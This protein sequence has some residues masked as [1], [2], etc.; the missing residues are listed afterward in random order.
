MKKLGVFWWNALAQI[1]QG[2]DVVGGSMTAKSVG[3]RALNI[4]IDV[5]QPAHSDF[6]LLGIPER[7]FRKHAQRMEPD[8]AVFIVGGGREGF[9]V[10]GL[11]AVE[12]P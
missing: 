9:F 8:L 11:E 10:Q 4:G 7:H 6:S 2:A 1:Q 3:G 5:P 12:H